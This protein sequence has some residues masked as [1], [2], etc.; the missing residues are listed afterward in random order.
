M[1]RREFVWAAGGVM[2]AY[3][4]RRDGPALT[5]TPHRFGPPIR[6]PGPS[7]QSPALGPAVFTRRLDRLRAELTTRKLDLFV[8]A[9]GTNFEYF[10]GYNPGRS[11]RLILLL[12]PTK[13]DPRIVCPSFEV[14]RLR[15]RTV[16]AD[17]QGWQEQDDPWKPVKAGLRA[18][19]PPHG[20]GRGCIEATLDY[21]SWLRLEEAAGGGWRWRSAAPVTERLRIVKD[22][23]EID[24]IRRAVDVT[25]AAIAATVAGLA[26]GVTEQEVAARLSGEMAAR[27]S[28]G[29]GLVQFGPSSA[30]PHG[31][32]AGGRLEKE[33]VVLIDAGSRVG[34]YTAD[35]TRTIWYGDTPSED[36]RRVYDLVYDAQTAAMELVKPL[37]VRCRELDRAARMVIADAGFGRYFTHRL[38]HGMG[39]DGHEPPY[40]VEGSETPLEPGMVFTIEPGIYQPDKFGVR[41]ED[42]V[43]VTDSGLE[44]LSQRPPKY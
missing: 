18:A 36:F 34:G 26:P 35:I 11:E 44:L 15:G 37:A 16:I 30:L 33:M 2:A 29:G 27:G 14:D 22:R 6:A 19:K 1:Q 5:T 13:G 17:L 40:L 7:A 4:K 28:P 10:T 3:V 12:V 25:Q 43:V 32:P 23:E 31:G 41:I 38:G 39:M 9:P 20:A 42:D 24:L 21:G 8:A